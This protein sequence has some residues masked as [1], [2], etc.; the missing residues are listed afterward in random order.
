MDT[1]HAMSRLKKF[2]LLRQLIGRLK[3]NKPVRYGYFLFNYWLRKKPSNKTTAQ[4]QIWRDDLIRRTH[5]K[6]DFG[7]G[8]TSDADFSSKDLLEKQYRS[9]VSLIK[10]RTT[11]QTVVLEIGAFDG[12]WTKELVAC[13]KIIAVDLFDEAEGKVRRRLHEA[14]FHGDLQFYKTAGDELG[15]IESASVDFV[16]SIDSMV[17]VEKKNFKKYVKEVYRILTPGGSAL[18]HCAA[19]NDTESLVRNF[20][21][22][23]NCE[24][25]RIFSSFKIVN[26]RKDLL[27]HGIIIDCSK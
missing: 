4:R 2:P 27:S 24:I 10:S 7:W 17:R 15:G 23:W 8:V 25:R 3:E 22:Y 21:C 14:S 19:M 1:F 20:V 26:M 5:F 12:N 18:I 6:Q 9:I 16:I 13:R 11:P